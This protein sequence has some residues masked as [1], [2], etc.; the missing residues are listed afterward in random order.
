MAARKK[1]STGFSNESVKEENEVLQT[2]DNEEILEETPVEP[3]ILPVV[4]ESIA[5][6]AI[7]P[8]IVPQPM[9][10]PKNTQPVR[11]VPQQPEALTLMKK[12][13]RHRN[14]PRLSRIKK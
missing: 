5:E 8:E 13:V 14:I 4:I 2:T 3:N 10:E 6:P 1:S 11:T 12:P 7:L 9:P